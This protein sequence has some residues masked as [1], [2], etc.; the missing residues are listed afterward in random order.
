MIAYEKR[1][2]SRIVFQVILPDG[3]PGVVLVSGVR[4]LCCQKFCWL[5]WRS[6]S[7]AAHCLETWPQKSR[8]GMQEVVNDRYLCCICCPLGC[9]LLCRNVFGGHFGKSLR[10]RRRSFY[11]HINI[12]DTSGSGPG[13]GRWRASFGFRL[14]LMTTRRC[15]FRVTFGAFDVFICK[16]NLLRTCIYFYLS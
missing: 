15:I 8:F 14:R 4:I 1:I 13:F 7:V 2:P 16:Y 3:R 12:K 9:F 10:T 6:T 11:C 5:L